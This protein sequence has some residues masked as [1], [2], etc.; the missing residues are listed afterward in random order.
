MGRLLTA[1]AVAG[2]FLGQ[3]RRLPAQPYRD[4]LL[5]PTSQLYER[6][7]AYAEEKDYTKVERSLEVAR[8][9]M[10]ALKGKFG[11]DVQAEIRDAMARKDGEQLLRS[12][13]RLVVLDMRDLMSLGLAAET[14]EKA[15]TKF[16]HAYLDYL[17]VSPV[18]QTRDFPA[19]Q[20]IKNAFRRAV[21]RSTYDQLRMATEDIERE[22][23][24][25]MADPPA[26]R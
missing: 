17:L 26:R 15:S 25:T 9:V 4:G 2:L 24:K 19:D 3:P 1:A 12:L 22:L 7:L 23:A 21:L 10:E 14:Q 11:T 20:R 8:P 16:R 18:I 5:L 13:R 6:M